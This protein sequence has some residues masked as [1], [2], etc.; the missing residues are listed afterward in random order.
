MVLLGVDPGMGLARPGSICALGSDGVV[1]EITD[2][3]VLRVGKGAKASLDYHALAR[4]VLASRAGHAFVK[5]CWNRPGEGRSG[6]LVGCY[7]AI[8]ATLTTAGIP[9]SAVAPQ[10]WKKA[11]AVP[12]AKDGARAR[13]SQL[14]PAH[15]GLWPLKK[16]DGKAEAALIAVYALRVLGTVQQ[17]EAA[18]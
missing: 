6:A 12:A 15:A 4:I 17:K 7:M 10:V 18:E 2:I 3:P 9:W 14:L 13:A 8:L 16:H 5:R 1:R 11:L